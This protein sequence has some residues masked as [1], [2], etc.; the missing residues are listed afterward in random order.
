[1]KSLIKI[2]L[3]NTAEER[4]AIY[5][6]RYQVYHQEMRKQIQAD[7]ERQM[8][9]D[10]LDETGYLFLA[11]IDSQVVGTVRLHIGHPNV[12]PAQINKY[13]SMYRFHAYSL[14]RPLSYSSR[15]MV[16]S[17]YRNSRVLLQM[18]VEVYRFAIEQW[19]TFNFCYC[20]PNLVRLYEKLGYREYTKNMNH[21]E[22]G[23]RV[24]MVLVGDDIHYLKQIRSPFYRVAKRLG[25][26]HKPR[27]VEWFAKQF[28]YTDQKCTS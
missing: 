2:E 5:K 9:V 14:N 3:A 7:H 12:L 28:P 1:M 15:L 21:P 18:L 8:I 27:S 16:T 4:Q 17:R 24:P 20:A 6:L 13:F 11:K 26:Q 25:K 23:I 10:E 22:T 19:A